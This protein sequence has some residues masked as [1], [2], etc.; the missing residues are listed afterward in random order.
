MKGLGGF[1]A[2]RQR[3]RVIAAPGD[4]ARFWLAQVFLVASTIV[5]VYLAASV[6]FDKALQFEVLREDRALYYL[7]VALREELEDNAGAITATAREAARRG[8]LGR[9]ATAGRLQTF[10]WDTMRESA[11]T[12]QVPA[13]VLTGTRRFHARIGLLVE[14]LT[15]ARISRALFQRRVAGEVARVRGQVL[16]AIDAELERLRRRLGPLVAGSP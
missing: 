12:F 1:A 16:P 14:D 2:L 4:A 10:V 5:G 6:G 8:D 7:L 3:I 13:R 9:L 15:R 11:Q